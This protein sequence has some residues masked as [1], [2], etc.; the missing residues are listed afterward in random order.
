MDSNPGDEKVVMSISDKMT[1]ATS[2]LCGEDTIVNDINVFNA[3]SPSSSTHT[4][5]WL[6]G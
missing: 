2:C 4:G 5:K 1:I 3:S 6:T